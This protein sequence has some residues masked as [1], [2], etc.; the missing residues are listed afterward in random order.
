MNS[1]SPNPGNPGQGPLKGPAEIIAFGIAGTIL[2]A[3]LAAR[4]YGQPLLGE[5]TFAAI[6]GTIAG[7]FVPIPF[8]GFIGAALAVHFIG[9]LPYMDGA[10]ISLGSA[11]GMMAG[12]AVGVEV[13]KKNL[14]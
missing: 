9:G 3:G 8:A 13:F 1:V 7:G 11:V 4:Y 2:G 6:G 14:L 10:V 12:A 5:V